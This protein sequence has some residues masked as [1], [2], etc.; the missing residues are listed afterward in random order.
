[1][2]YNLNI[3]WRMKIKL[4]FVLSPYHSGYMYAMTHEYV[5]ADI[6]V[7]EIISKQNVCT[8]KVFVRIVNRTDKMSEKIFLRLG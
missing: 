5:N 1:M 7:S 4:I 8:F 2:M 6:S 3:Y